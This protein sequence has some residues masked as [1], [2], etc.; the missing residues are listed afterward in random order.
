MRPT[1]SMPAVVVTV[2]AWMTAGCGGDGAADGAAELGETAGD[3]SAA[4]S[5]EDGTGGDGVDSTLDGSTGGDSADAESTSDDAGSDDES[6]DDGGPYEPAVYPSGQTH[7]P[8]TPFV[9]DTLDLYAA[10]NAALFEDVF[11]KAGASSTVSTNTLHCFAGEGVDLAQHAEHLQP[12]LEYFRGGDAAGTTSFDRVTEAAQ[13]GVH[14]GWAIAGEPSPIDLEVAALSP[15]VALVHYGT[16][17]M[18][19]GATYAS[20]L[21]GLHTNMTVLLDGLVSQGVVP[22]VFG[23]TRRGDSTNANRW[24]ATYNAALRGLAQ[25]RQIPFI[26]MHHAID[27]LPGNGLAGDGLHLEA[28]AEGACVLTPEGLTHG[29]NVRNLIALQSLQRLTAVLVDDTPPPDDPSEPALRVQGLGTVD[30]PFVVGPLPWVATQTTIGAPSLVDAYRACDDADESGPEHWYRFVLDSPTPLRIM[31]LDADGVDVDLHLLPG[32]GALDRCIVRDDTRIQGT[33]A[34]GTY[35][36]VVD[37][38]ASNGQPLSGDYTL[39][40]VACDDADP[41]CTTPL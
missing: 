13:S 37:T 25:R 6:T 22:I 10:S 7:S 2:L 36:L 3:D 5:S 29:Y 27:P 41:N 12:T 16:N 28:Y 17:D 38:W 39:L 4:S 31:V 18:G 40:M 1:P 26:D 23:M 33:L 14:A 19:W 11:M 32:D 9:A 24:V 15:R 20:A 35:T 30:V 34:A 21:Q 8:I